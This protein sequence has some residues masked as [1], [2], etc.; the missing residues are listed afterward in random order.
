MVEPGN[1]T[2]VASGAYGEFE[3]AADD[4]VVFG[5]Y[6]A[7]GTWSPQL[8][9]LIADRLLGSAGGTLIDVGANIGL[10][11]IATLERSRARCIAFEPAPDNYAR[12]LRNV[13]RHGLESRVEAHRVALDSAPGEVELALSAGNSGDHR[14][15]HGSVPAEWPRVRVPAARLDDVIASRQ[16]ARPVVMKLDAQGAEVR[17][18]R[19]AQ[20]ALQRVDAL[21]VEWWPAG[22]VRMG[23]SASALYAALGAL[24]YA[25]LLDQHAPPPRTLQRSTQ[26][27]ESMAWIPADGSDEGF[28]DLLLSKSETI[29]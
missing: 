27:F 2:V 17:V 9:A 18:L 14:L 25:A 23:D 3:G 29:G 22:L 1:G 26:L 15:A 8:V 16:L 12:L 11:A 10:V 19:G 7:S 20:Q 21:I 28:F 6:R 5:T 4:R 24:P 13:Q